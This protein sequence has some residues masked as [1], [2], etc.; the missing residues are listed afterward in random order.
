VTIT[1]LDL[2]VLLVYVVGINV[3]GWWLGRGQKGGTD[4]FLGSRN[5]P[6]W[7]VLLSVVATET[8]TLTFLSIPGVAY[9]GN[10]G[11]LQ[12]TIG[13]LLGRTVAAAVLLP[14]YYRGEL[15]TAYALLE[16]RFGIVARR[17]TS[18][19]FMV[20]RL[21]GDSVRFFATAIPLALMTGW[22]YP[23]S[24]II[25][26]LP[27][28]IYA[29]F[30]GI[31]AVVWVDALQCV[32]YLL[33]AALAMVALQFLVPGGWGSILGSAADAG[34][35]N[36]LNL[37][38]DLS[39]PYTLW[40][41]VVGGAFLSTASHGTDQL[42]VQRL[43]TC[44][45]LRSSQKALVGSGVAVIV[46]FAFFLVLGLG[47]WAFYQGRPFERS[48]EIFALFVIQELPAGA[49]GLLIAAVLAAAAPASSI[50]ALA[51]AAAYDFWAPA[52]GVSK[53][54][55][56]ILG[57]GKVFSLIWTALLVGG[58]IL[59]T[60]LSRSA[61]A[62]EV[63]LAIASWVYGGLLGAFFLGVLSERADTRSVMIGIAAGIG[64]V[65]LIW[66]FWR[67][68]VAYPWFA[69]IGTVITFSVGW[70]LGRG[71]PSP[72]PSAAASL[73]ARRAA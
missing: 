27:T 23:T 36:A 65:T 53:D 12:L 70:L 9:L 52:V 63:A 16:Q 45:D 66:V 13:Y 37:S 71:S 44:P 8:S 32:L 51:S 54:D 34:K 33:G 47:L 28:A 2:I 64:T 24:I 72:E 50:N 1:P 57:V 56:R 3:W 26:A 25:I 62:V 61:T 58:A 5:L 60:P 73:G 20:I 10:L 7:A 19:I 59:F 38:F 21:L 29:Y 39:Q 46:Q 4:Y 55:P 17:F 67:T 6:W 68:E 15:A 18:A 49:K 14:A 69:L 22:S 30:G 48:D 31:K 11:F 41:G 40:A 35:L 42:I 43:L